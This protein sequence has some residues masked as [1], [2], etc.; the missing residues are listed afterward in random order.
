MQGVSAGKRVYIILQRLKG[1]HTLTHSSSYPAEDKILTFVLL[2]THL[3]IN[4]REYQRHNK[5]DLHMILA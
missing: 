5:A 1:K 3:Q 2:D 4:L